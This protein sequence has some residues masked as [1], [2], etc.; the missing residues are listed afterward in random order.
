MIY[1]FYS[2]R[3]GSYAFYFGTQAAKTGGME[4]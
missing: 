4:E 3:I 1:T 2:D